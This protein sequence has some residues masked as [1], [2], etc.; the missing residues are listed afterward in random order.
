MS[1]RTTAR[2][3][4]SLNFVTSCNPTVG[5]FADESDTEV[6]LEAVEH[7]GFE[8]S[9]ARLNGMFACALWDRQARTLILLRDRLGE[10]P[11]YYGWIGNVLMFASELK[12]F[13]ACPRFEAEVDR[14]ALSLLLRHNCIPAPYSIYRAVAKLSPATYVRFSAAEVVSGRM[15]R[16]VCYWSLSKQ[17]EQGIA[18]PF[19]GSEEEA[20]DLLDQLLRKAVRLR[21]ASD[22]PLGAFLSGGI[23]SSTVAAL[24][25]AESATPVRTFTIGFHEAEYNEAGFAKQVAGHL[26]TDHTELYVTPEQALAVIPSPGGSVRR[27]VRRLFPDPYLPGITDGQTP[28]H[29]GPVRRRRG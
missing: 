23:D 26:Q 15:P 28:C 14:Q 19:A 5:C 27:A 3:T 17:V 11:L 4:T 1:P 7:W 21:M 12:A 24:M 13:K 2:F 6:L 8:A 18:T 20:V 9:L 10:K 25:Q 29:G 22:V 16:P